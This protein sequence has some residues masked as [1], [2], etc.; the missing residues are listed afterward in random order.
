MKPMKIIGQRYEERGLLTNNLGD[1]NGSWGAANGS[2]DLLPFVIR[3]F[4]HPERLSGQHGEQQDEKHDD[5]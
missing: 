2:G 1:G 4:T 3:H 5:R